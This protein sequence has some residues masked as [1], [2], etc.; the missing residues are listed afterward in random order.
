M[1]TPGTGEAYRIENAAAEG[2]RG[3]SGSVLAL[4]EPLSTNPRVTRKVHR[5]AIDLFALQQIQ[6]KILTKSLMLITRI[7]WTSP[8]F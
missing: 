5:F 4:P 1:S 8:L 2:S 7:D 6:R 3:G